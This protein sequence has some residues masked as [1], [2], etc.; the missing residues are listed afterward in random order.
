[1]KE[2]KFSITRAEMFLTIC[3]TIP[4]SNMD[5]T[6]QKQGVLSNVELRSDGEPGNSVQLDISL[7]SRGRIRRPCP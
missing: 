5:C 3:L 1:M 6:V 2:P 4:F 7:Q